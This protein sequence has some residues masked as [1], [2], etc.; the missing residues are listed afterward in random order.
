MSER[1]LLSIA[2]PRNVFINFFLGQARLVSFMKFM[3]FLELSFDKL[4]TR[5]FLHFNIYF[6]KLDIGA[7]MG[8]LSWKLLIPPEVVSHAIILN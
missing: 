8:S 4:P 3:C 1:P 7:G 2:E 6:Y 5:V